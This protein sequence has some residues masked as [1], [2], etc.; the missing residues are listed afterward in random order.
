VEH[1]N[2]LLDRSR[3]QETLIIVLDHTL[4]LYPD[5]QYRLVG[6]GA[7]LLHGADLPAGDI[8]ILVKQRSDVDA[9]GVALSSFQCLEA[10]AWLPEARQFYANYVVNGVEV[11]ISTVE[12]ETDSDLIE[13][14]GPGPWERHYVLLPCGPYSVPT[15]RLEL[16]LITELCR[17]RPD[18]YNPLLH[19]LGAHGCDLDLV[20]RGLALG[21]LSEV[22]QEDVLGQLQGL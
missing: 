4:P 21:R 2:P 11:G 14:F 18:R 15:V 9:F 3:L 17:D 7:A 19:H 12:V 20:R 22:V 13:T 8:D 16:R 6:T 1:L 10:P 5:I